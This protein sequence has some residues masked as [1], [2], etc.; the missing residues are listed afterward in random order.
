MF[1][2][3]T[4]CFEGGAHRLEGLL[5]GTRRVSPGQSHQAEANGADFFTGEL[6]HLYRVVGASSSE[7]GGFL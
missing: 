6:G 7:I 4:S 1:C 2:S 5:L 3:R